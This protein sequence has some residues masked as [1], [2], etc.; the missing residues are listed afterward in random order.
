MKHT[1]DLNKMRY[2]QHMNGDFIKQDSRH[3]L[4]YTWFQCR[5]PVACVRAGAR[6]ARAGARA[7]C[8]SQTTGRGYMAPPVQ[9]QRGTPNTQTACK[10]HE[11]NHLHPFDHPT[12]ESHA[13]WWNGRIAKRA[14]AHPTQ[15]TNTT[16]SWRARCGAGSQCQTTKHTPT[17]LSGFS[18]IAHVTR[19]HP[20][21]YPAHLQSNQ[22]EPDAA[23]QA[24]R[25]HSHACARMS[26]TCNAAVLM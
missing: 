7:E 17:S 8:G 20:K 10:R 19:S 3:N 21:H 1:V 25:R 16:R 5:D 12:C 24:N 22:R 4:V 18:C 9:H 15:S 6:A 14:K 2:E 26:D 23:R 11:G 13:P